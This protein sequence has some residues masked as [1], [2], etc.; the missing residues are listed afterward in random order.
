[1]TSTTPDGFDDGE[2]P[3]SAWLGMTV[4]VLT[5]LVVLATVALL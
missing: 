4:A 5:G 2:Q 3:R 1:M